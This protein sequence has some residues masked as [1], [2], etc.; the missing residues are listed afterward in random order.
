MQVLFWKMVILLLDWVHRLKSKNVR[1]KYI[2]GI[3]I[4]LIK[5]L[6]IY[7]S[8]YDLKKKSQVWAIVKVSSLKRLGFIFFA[9]FWVPATIY[10][11]L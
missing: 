4:T 11:I 8:F 5:S 10:P 3:K 9:L 7:F 2:Y 1:H 6:F